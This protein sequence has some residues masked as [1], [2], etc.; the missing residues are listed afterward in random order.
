MSSVAGF[1]SCCRELGG[2]AQNYK[3]SCMCAQFLFCQ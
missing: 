3:L 1:G 2:G